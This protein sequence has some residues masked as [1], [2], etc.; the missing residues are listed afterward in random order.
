MAGDDEDKK[1]KDDAKGKGDD[2]EK[3]VRDDDDTDDVN[4]NGVDPASVGDEGVLEGDVE[5]AVPIDEKSE[6]VNASMV[7][8]EE[9]EE[10]VRKNLKNELT[11]AQE[12]EATATQ[13]PDEKNLN[14]TKKIFI[15]LFLL[16]G[17]A[18]ASIVGVLL[19]DAKDRDAVESNDG[20]LSEVDQLKTLFVPISGEEIFEDQESP[21][22]QALKF[23]VEDDEL[24]IDF[25][26]EESQSDLIERYVM[27]VLY[28]STDGPNWQE[29][30]LFGSEYRTCEWPNIGENETDTFTFN[31]VDC[32]ESGNIIK[33]RLGKCMCFSTNDRVMHR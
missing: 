8:E 28:Y 29:D 5:Q 13:S 14:K 11:K 3:K 17:I 25:Y 20:P 9:L 6:I 7:N 32:D 23:L 18:F 16:G 33:I 24:E 27:M 30:L 10:K 21:Q 1:I 22:S 15:L 26:D 12:V 4:K 31:E 19:P 2:L